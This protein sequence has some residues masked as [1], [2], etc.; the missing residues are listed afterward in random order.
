MRLR[1]SPLVGPQVKHIVQVDVGQLPRFTI[2]S[3]CD[4][5]LQREARLTQSINAANVVPER[6]ELQLFI[7]AGC[8]PYPFQRAVQTFVESMTLF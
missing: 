5:P 4:V 6:S 7:P 1:L 3:C 8:L 2:D